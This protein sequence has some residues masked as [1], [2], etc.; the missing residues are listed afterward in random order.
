MYLDRVFTLEVV[1][2]VGD[3]VKLVVTHELD[4]FSLLEVP[5]VVGVPTAECVLVLHHGPLGRA[6]RSGGGLVSR[7]DGATL[8][9][10][11][12]SLGVRVE[13]DVQNMPRGCE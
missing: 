1:G 8:E 11:V 10:L 4:P 7:A 9:A 13:D 5:R 3:P 2:V 12:S 6:G